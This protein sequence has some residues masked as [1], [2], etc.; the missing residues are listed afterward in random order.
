MDAAA[1]LAGML[2]E[3][4]LKPDVAQFATTEPF[5]REPVHFG[6][7]RA[8]VDVGRAEDFP[9]PRRPAPPAHRRAL[10]HHR[11]DLG[12]RPVVSGPLAAGVV[13][14]TFARPADARRAAGPPP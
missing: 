13:P 3:G 8:R 2:V 11:P 7:Q 14:R 4:R 5:G 6:D 1:K 12:A 9:R 10:D